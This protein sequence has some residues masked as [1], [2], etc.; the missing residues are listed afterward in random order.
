MG[1]NIR[2]LVQDIKKTITFPNLAGKKI[3]IDAFNIIFQFL[4]IIRGRDGTP[5]KDYS[6]NTTSHL[7]GLFYRTINIMEKEIK[8]IFV[9]DGP[10]NPFKMAEIER[11]RAVRKE[12][13]KRFKEAQDL[14]RSED[15]KKFGQATSK[16]TSDMLE[17]ARQLLIAMGVPIVNAKQ[18]GEAQAAYL[19]DKK[20]AW[21][22][23]SQDYDS[24]LFGTQRM[25]RNLSQNRFKKV[26]NTQVAVPLEY[27][28]LNKLLEHNNITREQLVD[29]GILIG[30]DFFPGIPGVGPKTAINL[31]AD[32]Q[33]IDN[34]IEKKIEVKKQQISSFIELD[35][36]HQVRDIFLKP[37][38][39]A[40]MDLPKIKWTGPDSEKITEILV[41]SHNF[42]NVRV[43]R[44]IQR[45]NKLSKKKQA[46]LD[47]FF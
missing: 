3:A 41:E 2:P 44:A 38:V 9:F 16:L 14:G 43:E 28:G 45:L 47:E 40:V 36:L 42:N 19:V 39:H 13:T 6:G 27:L 8:P 46:R 30:L 31:I 29:I 12:A 37:N 22:V 26:K 34:L 32:H 10:P 4:S 33:S 23:G 20:I 17:D 18:D 1:V 25:V 7:S 5:L 15:A 11:R 24:L 35:T 21:A